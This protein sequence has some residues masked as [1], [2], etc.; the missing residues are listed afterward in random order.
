MAATRLDA[1]EAA[2]VALQDH[3]DKVEELREGVFRVGSF[4]VRVKGTSTSDEGWPWDV[5][6]PDG[7]V[8]RREDFFLLY[9]VNAP[10]E[11]FIVP[12]DYAR[13]AI[14]GAHW[15][16]VNEGAKQHRGEENPRHLENTLRRLK[17]WT[18]RM[19]RNRW[20]LLKAQD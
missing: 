15:E 1:L 12:S 19:Y 5:G 8:D 10:G 17:K 13:G 18:V 2:R 3:V 16:F 4:L 11:F 20:D 9:D 6:R 7:Y 14:E